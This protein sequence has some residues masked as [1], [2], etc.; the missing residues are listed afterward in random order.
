MGAAGAAGLLASTNPPE[1]VYM[2]LKI[3]FAAA[4]AIGGIGFTR[5]VGVPLPW[6]FVPRWGV[7]IHKA[8]HARR[9]ERRE[10]RDG[11]EEE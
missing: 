8:K 3:A 2:V 9:R 4:L 7:D 6:P 5:A 10:V 1:F 11:A